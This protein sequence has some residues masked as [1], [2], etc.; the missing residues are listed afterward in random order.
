MTR[1]SELGDRFKEY[2]RVALEHDRQARHVGKESITA[3]FTGVGDAMCAV[4]G[5]LA[6]EGEKPELKYAGAPI[7]LASELAAGI[8]EERALKL[9]MSASALESAL[10]R[11]GEAISRGAEL[12]ESPIEKRLLPWLVFEDYGPLLTFPAILHDA[13]TEIDVPKGDIMIVPQFGFAK[14]R[15]DF[16]LVARWK[17]QT[18]IVAVECDGEGYHGAKRDRIRDAY[19]NAW[20]VPTVRASGREVYNQPRDISARAAILIT[21]W[22]SAL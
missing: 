6:Y 5:R 14:Y 7:G 20:G 10:H 3:S 16:G 4:F 19:L 11:G 12:C 15:I 8:A 22:A 13:K 1:M 2:D 21:E 9:G 18:K 17:G